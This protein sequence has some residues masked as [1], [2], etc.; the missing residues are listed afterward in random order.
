M[1]GSL[2]KD[3]HLLNNKGQ[4]FVEFKNIGCSNCNCCS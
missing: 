4:Q 2:N 1:A 3:V